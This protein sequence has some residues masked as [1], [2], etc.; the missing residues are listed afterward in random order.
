MILHRNKHLKLNLF[1]GLFGAG[2]SGGGIAHNS[3]GSAAP[4]PA[5]VVAAPAAALAGTPA[6]APVAAP[7]PAGSSLDALTSFWDTPKNA[8]GTPAAPAADPTQQAVFT[9]DLNTVTESSRK[10]DFT[11]GLDPELATKALAGDPAALMS[12]MNHVAQNAVA[13]ATVNSGNMVNRGVAT[14]A[15]RINGALPSQIKK[16]QL[17]QAE[18]TNPVL[19]HPA[20]QP[21]VDA[22]RNM[23]FA[24]NPD[25]NPADVA[26]SVEALLVG[27]GTAMADS[28][29]AATQARQAKAAGEQDWSQFLG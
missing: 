25:A 14:G 12:M 8:D 7:A 11:G 16:V 2:G 18:S 17:S 15:S 20:A 1:S 19:Q 28:T 6:A 21:L 10:L 13:A 9:L 3:G 5:P 24:K 27:L 4:A 29:P 22:L 23:A 26:R